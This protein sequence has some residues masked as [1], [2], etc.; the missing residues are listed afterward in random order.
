MNFVMTIRADLDNVPPHVAGFGNDAVDARLQFV[1]A[2]NSAG[3]RANQASQCNRA[4]ALLPEVTPLGIGGA[5]IH[6]ARKIHDHS[7]GVPTLSFTF[8]TSRNDRARFGRRFSALQANASRLF[9][10]SHFA[11][12]LAA[13][14]RAIIAPAWQRFAAVL[15]VANRFALL[16]KV[17]GSA[18]PVASPCRMAAFPNRSVGP[19]S[20]LV[21]H[22]KPPFFTLHYNRLSE[23]PHGS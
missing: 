11:P 2:A 1:V 20:R 23:V 6:A 16:G 12:T 5:A 7:V 17:A 14:R 21:G 9:S 8:P 10:R 13:T 22:Y 19:G 3:K 4:F 15:A 18:N